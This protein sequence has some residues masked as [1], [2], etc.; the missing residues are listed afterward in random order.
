MELSSDTIDSLIEELSL[1]NMQLLANTRQKICDEN[2]RHSYCVVTPNTYNDWIL[3]LKSNR[4]VLFDKGINRLDTWKAL[5][6]DIPYIY[7]IGN[8]SYKTNVPNDY[9]VLKQLQKFKDTESDKYYF[10]LAG[11][12]IIMQ[13]FG[14]GNHRSA[15]YFYN[16][17][18]GQNISATQFEAIDKIRRTNKYDYFDLEMNPDIIRKNII[19]DLYK[20]SNLTGGSR[21][22]CKKTKRSCKK[23]RRS[24]KKTKRKYMKTKRK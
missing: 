24:R 8:P 11:L 6:N 4:M 17:Y 7:F 16:K 2:P 20:I 19:M 18:T 15:N 3:Y 13:V 1:F 21:I 23:T 5:L 22:S 10:I 14:D 12:M 9:N